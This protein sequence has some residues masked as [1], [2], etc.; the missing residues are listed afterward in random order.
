V[1]HLTVKGWRE[2]LLE[3]ARIIA[4]AKASMLAGRHTLVLGDFN[5]LSPLDRAYYAEHPGVQ[6]YQRLCDR[7]RGWAGTNDGELDFSVM[8]SFAAAGLVD[9]VAQRTQA[10]R[11]F[12]SYPT[13]LLEADPS[14]GSH[15]GR[16]MRI[17]YILASPKLAERCSFAGVINDD[18]TS[19]QS[20]HYPV[21]AEFDI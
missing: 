21:M 14:S 13:P 16:G 19:L 17:D 12:L 10:A 2:R 4:Q 20:D 9:L 7:E 6:D 15:L 1:L 3:A 11:P 5:A 18:A 8:E